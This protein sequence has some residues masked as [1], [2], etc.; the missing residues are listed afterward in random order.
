MHALYL[1]MTLDVV[2]VHICSTEYAPG[3]FYTGCSR[4]RN[5]DKLAIMGYTNHERSE[6]N[7]FPPV[8]R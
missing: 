5:K 6:F 1:G 8:Q 4:V 7:D 3:L 2:I